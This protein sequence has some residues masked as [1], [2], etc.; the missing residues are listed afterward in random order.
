MPMWP[1]GKDFTFITAPIL[2]Q[3]LS[4]LAST[5]RT[6]MQHKH[7]HAVEHVYTCASVAWC[8]R[9]GMQNVVCTYLSGLRPEGSS[10][11]Q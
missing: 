3:Q 5:A 7:K 11:L 8:L 6:C 2:A 4:I 9:D 1:P 10:P